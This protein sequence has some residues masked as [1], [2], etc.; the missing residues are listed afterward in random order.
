MNIK[1][2]LSAI[3][4][5]CIL[6]VSGSAVLANGSYTYMGYTIVAGHDYKVFLNENRTLAKLETTHPNKNLVTD[7]MLGLAVEAKSDCTTSNGPLSNN[8]RVGHSHPNVFRVA[9]SC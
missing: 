3:A 4:V 2:S 8:F 9:V 1:G 7:R 6:S 5:A